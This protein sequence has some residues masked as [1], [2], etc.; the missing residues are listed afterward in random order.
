MKLNINYFKNLDQVCGLSGIRVETPH[1]KVARV[2][3][4][5]ANNTDT[6]PPYATQICAVSND[7]TA[8][9][10]ECPKVS[11][12]APKNRPNSK[13]LTREPTAPLRELN[14]FRA[15]AL[16]N[17][18]R[19]GCR[20][21]PCPCILHQPMEEISA[22][23]IHEGCPG[24]AKEAH[25]ARAHCAVSGIMGSAASFGKDIQTVMYVLRT[26]KGSEIFDF[27]CDLQSCRKVEKK[28]NILVKDHHHG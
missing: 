8:N 9:Y 12:F 22:A 7:Y 21:P 10:R 16:K 4:I 13:W 2:S 20:F 15:L 26:V 6:Q 17:T 25:L 14:N 5:Y 19:L 24:A 23:A 18:I 1:K 3:A 28:L 27:V 11:K